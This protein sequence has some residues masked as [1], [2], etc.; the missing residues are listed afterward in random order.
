MIECKFN[1]QMGILEVKY[2]GKVDVSQMFEYGESIAKNSSY[3]RKLKIITDVTEAEYDITKEDLRRVKEG[4]KI[5]TMSYEYLKVAFIHAKPKETAYSL[6]LEEDLPMD[7]Y[8]HRIF[9]T[10]EAALDWLLQS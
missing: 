10:K 5:H 2:S 3:P 9:Y 7:K 1:D 6:L 8:I 4:L